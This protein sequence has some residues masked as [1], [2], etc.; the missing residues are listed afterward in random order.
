MRKKETKEL[1][2]KKYIYIK[3]QG[4]RENEREKMK[5][6]KGSECY[7]KKTKPLF[8]LYPSS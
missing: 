1:M 7:K 8:R 6:I 5:E 3:R 4:Q 2:R